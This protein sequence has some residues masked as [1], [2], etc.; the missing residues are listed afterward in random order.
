MSDTVTFPC[1]YLVF[2]SGYE[3]LL[4]E[5][6]KRMETLNDFCKNAEVIPLFIYESSR[7]HIVIT[8]TPIH[9][10]TIKLYG[11][12]TD[13]ETMRNTD[14][15]N[16]IRRT[17]L[18]CWS[19]IIFQVGNIEKAEKVFQNMN[20]L[21]YCEIYEINKPIFHNSNNISIV[22]VKAEAEAG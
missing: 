19:A 6:N 13:D 1:E 11:P 12:V 2:S 14:I 10:G 22:Y 7:R 9:N 8:P 5:N 16:M 3:S 20:K 17:R 4:I 15:S 21:N 18:E